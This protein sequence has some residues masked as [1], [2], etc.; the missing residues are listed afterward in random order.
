MS[1]VTRLAELEA[2]LKARCDRPGFKVNTDAIMSEIARLRPYLGT[3]RDKATKQFVSAEFAL[4]NP[5][6]TE[7]VEPQE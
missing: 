3:Y 7:L 1:T 6:T 5:D 4:A 2:K